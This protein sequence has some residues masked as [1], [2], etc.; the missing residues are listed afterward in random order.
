MSLS[1]DHSPIN[2]RGHTSQSLGWPHPVSITVSIFGLG[3]DTLITNILVS[4]VVQCNVSLKTPIA[5]SLFCFPGMTSSLASVRR[6]RK[7]IDSSSK[8]N[9]LRRRRENY[10]AST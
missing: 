10:D 8:S 9:P 5:C 3:I 7:N 1:L 4:T 6:R 2:S